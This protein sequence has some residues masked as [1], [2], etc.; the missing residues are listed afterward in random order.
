MSSIANESPIKN[1]L[2]ISLAGDWD[3]AL[4]AVDYPIYI[5]PLF[6]EHDYQ[7]GEGVEKV[8]AS[9]ITNTKR[10]S[11]FF[12]IV[13]DRDRT[14]QLST[15]ATVTDTYSTIPPAE[16]Y[17]SLRSELDEMG[18]SASPS[19]LYVSGNGGRQVLT[20]D[21]EGQLAPNCRDEIGMAVQLITSLDG[22]KKH[23]IRLVAYDKTNN[24]ELVG[25]ASESFNIAARHTRTI[26]E[27]HI[28]FQATITK[29]AGDWNEYIAPTLALMEDAKFNRQSAL[30]LLEALMED[31]NIPE[32][33]V[34]KAGESYQTKMAEDEHSIYTVVSGLSSYLSEE[35]SDKPE[36][37]DKFRTD[38]NKKAQ[39]HIKK[40]LKDMGL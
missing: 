37:L 29:M 38:I 27:R 33:H 30:S 19:Y 40:A 18:I 35:L 3:T 21:I 17:D 20:V 24:A 12:G 36:R 4:D 2:I 15:I 28:A 6:F 31:A 13:V 7:D 25:I 23:S 9:G 8:E 14:G 16:T 22:T 34:K 5:K 26:K 32:R 10:D 1:K 39:K 11:Q